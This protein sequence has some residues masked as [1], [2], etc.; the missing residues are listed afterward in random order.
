MSSQSLFPVPQLCVQTP[1]VCGYHGSLHI[2]VVA[3]NSLAIGRHCLFVVEQTLPSAQHEP[4]QQLPSTEYA[5]LF[6]AVCVILQ[7]TPSASESSGRE[8]CPNGACM[9][10]PLGSTVSRRVH[11]PGESAAHSPSAPVGSCWHVPQTKDTTLCRGGTIR[12]YHSPIL[13]KHFA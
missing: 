4:R 12:L 10:P 1:Y 3:V 8:H 9:M 13:R 11:K 7:G 6:G 2:P 5:W